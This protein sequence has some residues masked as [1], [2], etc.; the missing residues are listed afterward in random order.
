MFSA[1]AST[2]IIDQLAS[3]DNDE[4]DHH[5]SDASVFKWPYVYVKIVG[6][7][8][9]VPTCIIMILWLKGKIEKVGAYML[10]T[11]VLC[12]IA[13]FESGRE[14][15]IQH[16]SHIWLT[17]IVLVAF[18]LFSIIMQNYFAMEMKRVRAW[19]ECRVPIEL[20]IRQ[21]AIRNK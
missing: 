12:F 14:I 21:R 9:F 17:E 20:E 10:A 18:T 4:E 16:N 15:I 1:V 6:S 8:L 13:H 7:T 5:W 19:L 3:E 11:Y 2:A